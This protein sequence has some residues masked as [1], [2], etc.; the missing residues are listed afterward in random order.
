RPLLE[1]QDLTVEY[2]TVEGNVRAVD[3]ISLKLQRGEVLGLVGESGCGKSTLGFTL[4]RLLKGGDIKSGKILFEGEDL[5]QIPEEK[6]NNLRGSDISMIFQAS[7]NALNPLQKISNHFIDSLKV[8]EDWNPERWED[9]LKLLR[10]L[11]IPETRLVDYAFQFSGG[12]QQRIVIALTLLLNPKLIIADEPTTAL[13]VLVQARLLKLLKEII[14][15]FHLT[16]IYITHDLGVVAEITQRV[17]IMYAGQI[18]ETGPTSIIFTD[19]AHPYTRALVSAIPNV[20]DKSKKTLSFIPGTPPD[21][22]NP[23]L[24][25]MCCFVERCP[26]AKDI[27]KNKR[28]NN[29]TISETQGH[30]VKCYMHDEKYSSTFEKTQ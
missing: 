15:E 25:R 14:K 22:K 1:I 26:F 23:N 9:A 11:E 29:I 13:D 3:N 28:P 21:L 20:K 7:Q 4:L 6:M 10:R 27:C 18:V 30:V 2:P 24:R 19:A 17:S 16:V 8:H 5:T 12:M